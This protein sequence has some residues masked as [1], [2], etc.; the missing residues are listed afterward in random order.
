M[1]TTDADP[2]IAISGPPAADT[3]RPMDETEQ[4]LADG[5]G[6]GIDSVHISGPDGT[7]GAD[8]IEKVAKNATGEPPLFDPAP[9][10]DAPEFD[11][12]TADALKLAFSGGVSYEATDEG[13]RALFDKLELGH[14][15]ELR[16]SATVVA[17]AGKY[18][19]SADDEETITG[20]AQL[21]VDT[22]YIVPA[23]EL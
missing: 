12:Q 16:V 7:T 22:V 23:E 15:Y 2:G 11:G 21:K 14:E 18:K 17:K 1:S 3:E 20:H 8:A 4:K 9:Y 13:G 5:M 10:T 19:R 6:P